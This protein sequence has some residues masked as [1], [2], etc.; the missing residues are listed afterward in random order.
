MFSMTY[1]HILF[2]DDDDEDER[3]F[4]WGQA[5]IIRLS[6]VHPQRSDLVCDMIA[7]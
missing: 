1:Q 3:F 2:D 5:K 4:V 6:Q 7:I